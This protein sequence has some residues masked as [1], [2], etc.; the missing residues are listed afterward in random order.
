MARSNSAK[1]P[2]IWNTSLLL[3]GPAV[4]HALNYWRTK[5]AALRA[6]EAGMALPR[7][8]DLPPALHHASARSSQLVVRNR[9]VTRAV[10]PCHRSF[11]RQLKNLMPSTSAEDFSEVP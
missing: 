8:R 7:G 4:F 9:C 3:T 11:A 5:G 1:A 10:A 6:T 2:A